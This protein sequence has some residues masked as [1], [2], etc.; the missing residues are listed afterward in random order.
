MERSPGI[1]VLVPVGKLQ[2]HAI[3]LEGCKLAAQA[4]NVRGC[5]ESVRPCV[6][7]H[8]E[9]S[10]R[11]PSIDGLVGSCQPISYRKCRELPR[12]LLTP[13]LR[14]HLRHHANGFC[15]ATWGLVAERLTPRWQ[16]LAVDARGH[17]DSLG[18]T[19]ALLAAA[20]QPEWSRRLV[21]LDPVVVPAW[22]ARTENNA[23]APLPTSNGKPPPAIAERAAE[24]LGYCVLLLAAGNETT[25][26]RSPTGPPRREPSRRA[27]R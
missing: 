21:L 10:D 25:P 9:T 14:R 15:A 11:V 2:P 16:V 18:G 1:R 4:L 6:P 5:L 19:V 17:G 22:A 12:L 3:V 20:R 13:G 26:S 24:V 8:P 7:R 23:V 27:P